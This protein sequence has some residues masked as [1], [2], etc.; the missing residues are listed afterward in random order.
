MKI[1]LLLLALVLCVPVQI[2]TAGDLEDGVAAF[3]KG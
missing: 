1:R 3:E 2:A